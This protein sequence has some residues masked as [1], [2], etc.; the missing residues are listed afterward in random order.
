MTSTTA[1]KSEPSKKKEWKAKPRP[2]PQ[3]VPSGDL[4][5]TFGNKYRNYSGGGSRWDWDQWAAT[6]APVPGSN[7]NSRSSDARTVYAPAP[8]PTNDTSWGARLA[9]PVCQSEK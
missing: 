2:K 3:K 1:E 5:F 6:K 4:N 7:Q 8:A 9:R